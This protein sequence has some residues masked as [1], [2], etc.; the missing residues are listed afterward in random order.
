MSSHRE[1]IKSVLHRRRTSLCMAA[2][3]AAHA[4]FADCE[5]RLVQTNV[6]HGYGAIVAVRLVKRS[7]KAM[8]DAVIFATRFDMAPE[9]MPT[10]AAPIEAL[11]STEPGVYRF[12]VN[13]M[14]SDGWQLSLGTRIQGE[15][16][17]IEK[18][19]SRR[20]HR[21]QAG[22]RCDAMKR[23]A[24]TDLTLAAIAATGFVACLIDVR[25]LSS[26]GIRELFDAVCIPAVAGSAVRRL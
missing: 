4:N 13:L 19:P 25:G 22:P 18:T 17:A 20:R 24:L 11:P 3:S 10:I 6:K 7:G 8:P 1:E 23:I 16:D 5:F 14:M 21:E 26:P 2:L 9:G 15:T 12:K